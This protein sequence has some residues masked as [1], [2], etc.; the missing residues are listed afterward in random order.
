MSKIAL[1]QIS[2]VYL[3]KPA[4]LKLALETIQAAASEGADLILFPEAFLSGYPDWVWTIPNSAGSLLNP[5]YTELVENAVSVGDEATIALCE[6]ANESGIHIAI[7]MSERN[8]ESSG[9]S[10]FNSLMMI[11]D[12]GNLLGVHRKLIA[13]GGERLIWGQGDG[14]SLKTHPTSMGKIGGLICWENYMPLARQSLYS[15]GVQILLSPTWDKSDNWQISMQHVAREGGVFVLSSCTAMH[16]DDIPDSMPFKELYPEDRMWINNGK[17]CVIGPNGKYIVPPVEN[18][19]AIIYAE[20]DV[21]EII[22]AK[23][24]FDAAGHYNRPDVFEFGLK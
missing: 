5:L 23:R 22:G 4:T 19:K 11:D 8:S 14:K 6:A 2:P 18:E 15:Q 24:M 3:N 1:A 13:T 17:S 20:I 10:L 9:S 7:G 21:R 16:R 12:R